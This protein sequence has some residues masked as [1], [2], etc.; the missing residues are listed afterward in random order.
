LIEAAELGQQAQQ[1]HRDQQ[2]GRR[3]K[4]IFQHIAQKLVVTTAYQQQAS[5]TTIT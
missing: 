3:P 2:E 5:A 1:G 4:R